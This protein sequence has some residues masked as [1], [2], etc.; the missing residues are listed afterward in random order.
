MARLAGNAT[1][2][3]SR[4]SDGLPIATLRWGGNTKASPAASAHLGC[5][6]TSSVMEP[7]RT[8]PNRMSV[9]WRVAGTAVPGIRRAT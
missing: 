6:S 1:S 5:P 4:S 9:S 3:I 8:N 2:R 7:V